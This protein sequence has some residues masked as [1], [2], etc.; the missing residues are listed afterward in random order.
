METVKRLAASVRRSSPSQDNNPA[1]VSKGNS[2]VDIRAEQTSKVPRAEM[3]IKRTV[4]FQF[5]FSIIVWV[6]LGRQGLV[7]LQSTGLVLLRDREL[8]VGRQAW[9]WE[10]TW[11]CR[12]CW[13]MANLV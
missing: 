3:L 4:L 9:D 13:P 10:Q 1:L 11:A 8:R 6:S 2:A 7:R 5:L 12:Q